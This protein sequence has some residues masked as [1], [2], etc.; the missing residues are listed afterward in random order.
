MALHDR[1]IESIP[2][3][4]REALAATI[5][6][7]SF[8]RLVDFVAAERARIDTAIY[9]PAPDVFAALQLTPLAEVRAV[10][11]GQDPYHG[12]GQAHGLAFSVRPG[13]RPPPSLR[14]ILAEWQSDLGLAP[15]SGG[16]LTPW[17]RHGVLLL[18]TILTVRRNGANSHKGQGWEEFTDS[19]ICA[20]SDS[21]D[22]TAFLLWGRPA[23]QKVPLIDG[24]HVV[25][26]SAH[27]SPLSARRG[28]S[29]FLGS[30]PFSAA[31]TRLAELGER[32][33]DWSLFDPL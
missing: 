10:I 31:N 33:I 12:D 9:P 27:P 22:P 13:I 5:E 19:I 6:A 26:R 15:A 29:P 14:N 11:L 18:N 3:D 20:V 21:L 8:D 16:S 30:R 28:P 23:Q 32:T 2:A 25:I 24:R 4:W 7:P 1:M 17:A